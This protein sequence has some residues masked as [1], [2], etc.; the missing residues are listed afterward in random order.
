MNQQLMKRRI[1]FYRTAILQLLISPWKGREK[2]EKKGLHFQ[3]LCFLD[4]QY[5]ANLTQ[6]AST[7]HQQELFKA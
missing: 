3:G 4:T 1:T 6:R 2:K 7:A 5:K